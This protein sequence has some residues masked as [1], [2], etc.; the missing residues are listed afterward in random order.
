MGHSRCPKEWVC[1]DEL[2]EWAEWL[3]LGL[4]GRNRWRLVIVLSG[5]LFATG[6]RTVTAWLR[7]AGVSTDYKAYYY[8]CLKPRPLAVDQKRFGPV[9]RFSK[10][11]RLSL[12]G[13]PLGARRESH[14]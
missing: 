6:R 1:P 14:A 8:S 3:S 7:A 5:L 12:R 13:K 2:A 4:H 9:R 11:I 10:K